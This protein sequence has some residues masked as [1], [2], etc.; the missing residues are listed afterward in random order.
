MRHYPLKVLGRGFHPKW[1]P[2]PLEGPVLHYKREKG[3][4]GIGY[5]NVMKSCFDI[6]FCVHRLPLQTFNGGFY[7]G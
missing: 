5:R 3:P 7:M 6:Y 2:K 1:H 4:S